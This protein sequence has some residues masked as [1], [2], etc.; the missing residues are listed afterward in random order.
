M[1]TNLVISAVSRRLEPLRGMKAPSGTNGYQNDTYT[2]TNSHNHSTTN[3]KSS[4]N[5]AKSPQKFASDCK[6]Q[7]TIH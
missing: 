6:H 3:N 7:A 4:L 2:H 5:Q 1:D